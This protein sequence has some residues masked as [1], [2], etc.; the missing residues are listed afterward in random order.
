MSVALDPSVWTGRRDAGER[1]DTARVF[2]YVRPYDG[3]SPVCGG[4]VLIGFACDEGV[5]RNQG[6]IGAA[7]GPRALRR[8]LA[9]LPAH[10]IGACFDGG[11]IVCE[12]ADLEGA[13]AALG[14]RVH[15]VLAQGGRP[16]VLGG[17]HELAWGTYSGLRAWLDERASACAAEPSRLLVV[18]L[19]AHFDLRTTRPGN[20][21]TPFDQIARDCERRAAALTYA[22][23]GVNDLANTRALF[24][25]AGEIGAYY[26]LD[27][28]MQERHLGERLE[29]LDRLIGAAD[30]VYLTIDLDVLPAGSAPGVSAPAALGV[31]PAVIEAMVMRVGASPKLRVADIAEYNPQYDQD[32]RTAR[33]AARLVHRLLSSGEPGG[34]SA[35]AS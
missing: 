18:N 4:S 27:A 21:G 14:K 11:D 31:P 32:N 12:G 34:A 19:D 7:H 22:C 29:Q 8:A 9:G 3:V 1:G 35:S 30:D 13:Q 2:E 16:I 6:R 26:V 23:F 10:R 25:R 28:D 5:R 33:L 24:E 15:R 17:G 20:S